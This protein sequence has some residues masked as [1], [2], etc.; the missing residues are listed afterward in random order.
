MMKQPTRTELYV[1]LGL[2]LAVFGYAAVYNRREDVGS[3][4]PTPTMGPPDAVVVSAWEEWY[5]NDQACRTHIAPVRKVVLGKTEQ[6][7]T[8]EAILLVEANWIGTYRDYFGN[9]E[10]PGFIGGPCRGF[11][12]TTPSPQQVQQRMRFVRYDTG[13]QF[14]RPEF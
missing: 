8:A 13:W 3:P 2:L 10:D 4:P 6:G 1:L 7:N 14:R 11:K 12:A 9:L 5:A